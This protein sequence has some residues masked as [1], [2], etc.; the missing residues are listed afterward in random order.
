[1]INMKI[2]FFTKDVDLTDSLKVYIE[3]KIKSFA[4]TY[5]KNA[6]EILEI[7]INLGVDQHHRHGKVQRVEVMVY[8]PQQILRAKKIANDIYTA[9]DGI[10]PKLEKQIE[11]YKNKFW[12][13]KKKKQKEFK[14][15]ISDIEME[16]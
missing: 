7:R 10:I 8:I 5:F 9:F 3:N 11:R 12:D 6:L 13:K 4:E 15:K 1:M 16:N 14:E 2:K